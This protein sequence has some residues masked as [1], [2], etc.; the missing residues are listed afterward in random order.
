[1]KY[2][3]R[4]IC[5]LLGKAILGAG[6]FCI[7]QSICR[8]NK[9]GRPAQ[10]NYA[11]IHADTACKRKCLITSFRNMA[12]KYTPGEHAIRI[13]FKTRLQVL[14]YQCDFEKA[15]PCPIPNFVLFACE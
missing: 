6:M 15:H 9:S 2:S 14:D 13:T 11:Y 5:I 10:K 7:V 12:F 3:T 8:K 1:M 4:I